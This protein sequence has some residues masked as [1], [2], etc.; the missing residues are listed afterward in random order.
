MSQPCSAVEL[1][2]FD[3]RGLTISEMRAAIDAVEALGVLSGAVLD[4]IDVASAVNAGGME[5]RLGFWFGGEEGWPFERAAAF[6]SVEPGRTLFV[7]ASAAARSDAERV[8]L[9]V[10]DPRSGDIEQ[11]LP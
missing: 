4:A 6:A 5:E 10:H 9:Q 3:A 11:R 2:L 7:S 8:G 1:V